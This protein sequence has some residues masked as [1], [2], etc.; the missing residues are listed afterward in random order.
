MFNRGV[1]H[2]R[3]DIPKD[4]THLMKNLIQ[5]VLAVIAFIVVMVLMF[6]PDE[7][8][9]NEKKGPPQPRVSDS[10][11]V[12]KKFQAPPGSV[13]GHSAPRKVRLSMPVDTQTVQPV[14]IPNVTG[15]ETK[16]NA[17]GIGVSGLTGSGSLPGDLREPPETI[18]DTAEFVIQEGHGHDVMSVAIAPGNRYL[19]SA[20]YMGKIK[21]WDFTTGQLIRN[22]THELRDEHGSGVGVD[23]DGR[24]VVTWGSKLE[25]RK[26][27]KIWSL[28]EN[29][30]IRTLNWGFHSTT[31][32]PRGKY[33]A[34]LTHDAAVVR[35][36]NTSGHTRQIHLDRPLAI[37]FDP[38]ARFCLVAHGSGRLS[39]WDLA[40]N[41]IVQEITAGSEKIAHLKI[42]PK[43]K[44]AVHTAGE[45]HIAIRDLETL[46][47]IRTIE[48]MPKQ[49]PPMRSYLNTIAIDPLGRYI[50]SAGNHGW[51]GIWSIESG[52]LVRAIQGPEKGL[53]SNVM[54]PGIQALAVD[55]TGKRLVAG[56][57]WGALRVWDLDT[58]RLLQE[59]S[60]NGYKLSTSSPGGHYSELAWHPKVKGLADHPVVHRIHRHFKYIIVKTDENTF[61]VWDIRACRLMRHFDR[62][63][64]ITQCE[65]DP[66][67]RFF[68]TGDGF[69]R[70]IFHDLKTGVPARI[71]A[72]DSG[73]KEK[74]RVAWIQSDVSGTRV[75]SL[76]EKIGRFPRP[77]FNILNIWDANTGTLIKSI[78]GFQRFKVAPVARRVAGLGPDGFFVWR[79]D[80]G[81]VEQRFPIE[82]PP[83]AYSTVDFIQD[84]KILVLGGRKRIWLWDLP[85][86][87]QL[88]SPEPGSHAGMQVESDLSG[89]Y[90]IYSPVSRYFWYEQVP[91]GS[92]TEGRLNYEQTRQDVPKYHLFD[93]ADRSK[94]QQSRKSTAMLWDIQGQKIALEIDT[95]GKE[96]E[97]LQTG[98]KGRL[99]AVATSSEVLVW[100][101]DSG[102]QFRRLKAQKNFCLS[103]LTISP[104]GRYLAAASCRGL[105]VWD[106][107]TGTM[108]R[109]VPGIRRV[110]RMQI[111]EKSSI[112]KE[113]L[114]WTQE[115][116]DMFMLTEILSGKHP[117]LFKKATRARI[118]PVLINED[119]ILSESQHNGLNLWHVNTGNVLTLISGGN[120]WIVYDSKGYFDASRYGARLIVM[121]Q[122]LNTFGVDQF[123]IFRNRPDILLRE[124]ALGETGIIDHFY[125][126]YRR[127][128]WKAGISEPA[129]P[130]ALQV[131]EA[132]IL[133][134]HQDGQY[135]KVSFLLE[136]HRSRLKYYNIYVNNV[137]LFGAYGKPI[138]GTTYKGQERVRLCTGRNKI[139]ITCMN[140]DGAESYRALTYAQGNKT[141]L[142]DLYFIAFGVSHYKNNDL[143]LKYAAKDAEDLENAIKEI[144]SGFD[145]IR[146]RAFVNQ[147]VTATSV[148]N[149]GTLLSNAREDDTLVLFLAG[150]GLH[151]ID[152][153]GTYYFL[154]HETDLNNLAST[155]V[156]FDEIENILVNIV[157]RKKLLLIDSCESGEVDPYLQQVFFSAANTRG[158]LARTTRAI[159]VSPYRRD[160]SPR[161]Y[162]Y[163]RNRYIYNDLLR[164]SGTIVL[165]S[166]LG[167]EFSYESDDLENG[168]FTESLLNAF[169]SSVADQNSDRVMT[170]DEL[171]DYVV[172]AVAKMSEGLQHPTIDRDNIEQTIGFSLPEVTPGH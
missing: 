88:A 110:Q 164:R 72:Y 153:D 14:A 46:T 143:D 28:Q 128:L 125:N 39:R 78:K 146:Y 161:Y 9:K 60:G 7:S 32:G 66:A 150:H 145:S 129:G 77:R 22:F 6:L 104:T 89:R 93:I 16:K 38:S 45:R 13:G 103:K 30:L 76:H 67:G 71:L 123:A 102:K 96:I 36:V 84:G 109:H 55:E 8:G 127:R 160:V 31:L 65:F 11:V 70:V 40:A 64:R 121:A 159:R 85:D 58:G 3:H 63:S 142:G 124:M 81:A 90:I 44:Y 37:A 87:R 166:S 34:G 168:F 167:G 98:Q 172:E 108:I 54:N 74:R 94:R 112:S 92:L 29:R 134:L 25:H 82:F 111:L 169:S 17:R 50:L 91:G 62:K 113:P 99:L 42:D 24:F 61:N 68:I 41:Q 75:V 154:T 140:Q 59:F 163:D 51:I 131:P 107:K 80:D 48:A 141:P 10:R 162:L 43:G 53:P 156:S 1:R 21:L 57:Q 69:D 114:I 155:A 86:G 118:S 158:I 148:R 136:D 2:V 116:G 4:D 101:L 151:D 115:E 79:L 171:R 106:L 33:I 130:H 47:L 35:E 73:D 133:D 12:R 120:Q 100:H 49:A 117:A 138:D 165:S 132:K 144:Q 147:E 97:D 126:R 27:L 18:L 26:K 149:A 56:G 152:S 139:E 15:S 137:P 83:N 19:L 20:D 170:T 5:L 23:P 105:L 119:Y 52:T 122:G 95:G 135:A 157:P